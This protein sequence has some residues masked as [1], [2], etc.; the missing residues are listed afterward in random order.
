MLSLH[1]LTALDATPAE[2]VEMAA[3]LGVDAVSLF[4]DMPAAARRHYPMVEPAGAVA[5]ARRLSDAGLRIGTLEVFALD[6]DADPCR[7]EPAL[8]AGALLGGR[9]ATV[10]LH[11][12]DPAAAA[13]RLA[14]FAAVAARHGIVAALEFN[15]FSAITCLDAAVSVV[16]AAG[17]G[18]IVL[19]CLHFA[20]SG[21]SDAGLGA[22]A[23]LVRHMQLCDGPAQAP[24]AA[25]GRAGWQEA[26]AE[27][28]LPGHGAFPLADWL[29][30][31]PPDCCFDVEVPQA[32]ARRAGVPAAERARRA[33][34]ATRDLLTGAGIG[35]VRQ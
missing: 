5:L 4:V 10:H 14:A 23:G 34:E 27:R 12:C 13:A 31:M 20:R 28:M 26:I 18:E 16:R 35:T 30:R 32:S 15:A 1:H 19:D 24:E 25:S 7:F 2:L 29:S 8:A 6:D 33:V 22:A 21:G 3:R 9:R 17:V 11:G